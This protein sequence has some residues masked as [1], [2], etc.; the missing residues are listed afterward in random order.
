MSYIRKNF[1]YIH[2]H[3]MNK[4]YK[5]ANEYLYSLNQFHTF[6]V[7]LPTESVTE[8]CGKSSRAGNY[9]IINFLFMGHKENWDCS[10]INSADWEWGSGDSFKFNQSM[11][12]DF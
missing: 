8:T 7:M 10:T 11:E 2:H 9:M 1:N 4:W 6:K 12:I 3:D 5:N